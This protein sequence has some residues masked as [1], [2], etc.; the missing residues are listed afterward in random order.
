MGGRL[1]SGNL[2]DRIDPRFV[3]SAGVILASLGTFA[4]VLEAAWCQGKPGAAPTAAELALV[5][6]SLV[7]RG[8]GQGCMF[9]TF[10][11]TV[12]FGLTKQQVS[13]G[14]TASRMMQQ[15]GG[16]FGTA[17]LAICLQ[18]THN[19]FAI[20]FI[21]STCTALIAAFAIP[22]VAVSKRAEEESSEELEI[23]VD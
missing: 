16:A 12:Y 11:T 22:F 7:V 13:D 17:I 23:T 5:I 21:I 6:I 20:T 3:A 18:F 2:I 15:L 19:N 9:G 14:T 8:A 4:F 10:T 1:V